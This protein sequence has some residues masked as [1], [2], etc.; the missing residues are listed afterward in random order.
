MNPD[1]SALT[2]NSSASSAIYYSK[3]DTLTLSISYPTSL[4]RQPM[5]QLA[6]IIAF[7]SAQS[8]RF[9]KTLRLSSSWASCPAAYPPLST[10]DKCWLVEF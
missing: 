8:T 6:S 2:V 7:F 4:V 9:A 1:W 10:A 5:P 3:I